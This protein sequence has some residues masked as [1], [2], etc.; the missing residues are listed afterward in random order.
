MLYYKKPIVRSMKKPFPSLLSSRQRYT[1]AFHIDFKPS[2][3]ATRTCPR[4][5]ESQ[6]PSGSFLNVRHFCGM[7]CRFLAFLEF[8]PRFSV[9]TTPA[10]LKLFAH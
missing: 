5:P 4:I 2:S 7:Q 10:N 9:R 6:R 1:L 8:S 3:T